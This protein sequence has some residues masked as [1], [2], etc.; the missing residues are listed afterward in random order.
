MVLIDYVC[1]ARPSALDIDGDVSDFLNMQY[2]TSPTTKVAFSNDY[3][4]IQEVIVN[5]FG[6][7]KYSGIQ[8]KDN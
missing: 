3:N 2:P 1:P 7:A 8:F 4:D 5:D 6:Q